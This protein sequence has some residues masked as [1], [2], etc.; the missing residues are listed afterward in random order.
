MKNINSQHHAVFSI[1][2]VAAVSLLFVSA[3]IAGVNV[4]TSW[5]SPQ[6]ETFDP[7]NPPGDLADNGQADATSDVGY[8]FGFKGAYSNGKF[9]V[10][11]VNVTVTGHTHIRE[12]NNCDP[13]LH[14]HEMGHNTLNQHEFDQNT[15]RKFEEAMQGIED[16]E[17]VSD[18]NSTA[19]EKAQA[20]IDRRCRRALDA[21][22]QQIDTVNIKYDDITDHGRN[23]EPNS[24]EGVAEAIREKE[25][26][27]EPGDVNVTPRD[28][29]SAPAGTGIGG[30]LIDP[31]EH[32]KIPT[33]IPLSDANDPCDAVNGRGAA[34]I[35][36]MIVIGM[37]G[38]GTLHLS[39]AVLTVIDMADPCTTLLKGLIF[40]PAYM[41]SNL[42]GYQGMI[43][44]YLDIPPS[45]YGGGIDNTIGSG[46]LDRMQQAADD[47][48]YLC[49]WFY[50]NDQL[51]DDEGNRLLPPPV[52]ADGILIMGVGKGPFEEIDRFEDYTIATLMSSWSAVG[53][54]W[55]DLMVDHGH[56]SKQSMAIVYDFYAPPYYCQ[57]SHPVTL[58]LC[59]EEDKALE[60]FFDLSMASPK[61]AEGVYV[62]IEDGCGITY[63]ET[64]YNPAPYDQV[65]LIDSTTEWQ[66]LN[67]DLRSAAA[68]GVNLGD[69]TMIKIGIEDPVGGSAGV[70]YVDDIRAQDS[71]KFYETQ[72]DMDTDGDVDFKDFAFIADHWLDNGFWPY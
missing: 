7:A 27:A 9:K 38:N 2:I 31:N 19:V 35:D 17:F 61:A 21:L 16:M 54:G 6:V 13:N 23:E 47:G 37:Q 48:E 51:F 41:P 42:P 3:V 69:I 45:W 46:W 65:I 1:F 64:F 11:D 39:D 70:I 63:T 56:E 55:I 29:N 49:F 40:N 34:E 67:M 43:Q 8:G 20:E 12:P 28:A 66:S 4:T 24:A 32:I 33:P 44:G 72:G 30:I 53:S 58:D 68:T 71:R 5:G 59:G 62:T 25:N 36:K 26:A 52:E 57:A 15:Q 10:T 50:S 18:G 22:Q 60:V 14:A